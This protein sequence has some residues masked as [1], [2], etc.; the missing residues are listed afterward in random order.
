MVTEKTVAE[1]PP[2]PVKAEE[3]AVEETP[4]VEAEE[5][6]AEEA[7]DPVEALEETPVVEEAP[8][9]EVAEPVA[10]EVA[11]AEDE[12]EAEAGDDKTAESDV[13][14][15]DSSNTVTKPVRKPVVRQVKAENNDKPD[16]DLGIVQPDLGF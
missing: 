6:M 2:A 14:V 7:V 10:G 13:F 1:E 9:V 4:V 16:N 8:A 15:L 12:P 5:P 3:P 11:P